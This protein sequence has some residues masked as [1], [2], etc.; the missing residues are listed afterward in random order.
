MPVISVIIPAYRAERWICEAVSS[1][2]SQTWRNLEVIV[3]DDGSPDA[4]A[5]VVEGI[6]DP[7]VRLIRQEN[8]GAAAAR[9]RG[10]D[11][12]NGEYIQFLDAD[13]LMAADKLEAQMKALSESRQDSVAS[14]G[15]G[16]FLSDP[17]EVRVSPEPVWYVADPVDW[18][19]C[20]LSGGGMMHSGAWLVPRLL[21][22]RAGPWDETLS[23]HDDGEFFTR[24]LLQASC[25]VFVAGALVYYR[26]VAHSLSRNTGRRAMVSALAVCRS[27][28]HHLL[29]AADT[30]PVRRALATQYGQFAYEFCQQAPDLC[31]QALAAMRALGVCP[32]ACIGGVG[33]RGLVRCMGFEHAWKIRNRLRSHQ[34]ETALGKR[35]NG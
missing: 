1:V 23:L 33:F 25:N 30:R 26:E 2:L 4:T 32:A 15:W 19:V 24:V 31:Q 3:V 10:I 7:R 11:L 13:D 6:D 5:A 28:H 12:A 22:E 20:S 27:R 9:N 16:K 14:C 29:A 34:N 8:R 17:A 18:L 21:I 35:T